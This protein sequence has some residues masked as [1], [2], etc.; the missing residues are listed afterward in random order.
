MNLKHGHSF[1]G[2]VSRTYEAW[3]SMKARCYNRGDNRY[4][5][6]GARGIRVCDTWRN[7]FEQF[8]ADMG[9]APAGLSLDRIDND[10]DYSAANC[11]WATVREQGNNRRTNRVVTYNGLRYTVTQL[12]IEAGIKRV[13]L[14]ARLNSGWPLERAITKGDYRVRPGL[15]R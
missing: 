5:L 15:S 10:G 1:I 2:R 8:L 7:S 6:Y 4:R 3:H 9:E 12:A 13:T 14:Y 11:R